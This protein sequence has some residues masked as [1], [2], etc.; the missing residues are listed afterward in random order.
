MTISE[1]LDTGL[2]RPD[3]TATPPQGTRE[4]AERSGS[5]RAVRRSPS[6]DDERRLNPVLRGGRV[7][8]PVVVNNP[9]GDGSNSSLIIGVV[10]VII[11]LIVL[12]WLFFANGSSP[13][14]TPA[15][16]WLQLY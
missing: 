10:V 6:I 8:G 4:A 9:P 1:L 3:R 5:G 7:S 11:V 2:E 15:S 13:S 14:G 16:S 12:W